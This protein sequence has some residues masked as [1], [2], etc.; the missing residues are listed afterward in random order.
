MTRFAVFVATTSG[1]VRIERI[2]RERAP[3]SMVCLRRSST[4]LPI[5]PAYDS[6]VR[7]GSGVIEKTFGP[8]EDGAFR[9]DVSEAIETGE[10]WQLGVFVAH[11]L[12]KHLL[13]A[14]DTAEAIVWLTGHVDYDLAVGSVG[15]LAEKIHASREAIAAWVALGRAVTMVVHDGPD[16]DAVL[17]AGVPEGAR[18]VTVKSAQDALDALGVKLRTAQPAVR[19]IPAWAAA[20]VA[21]IMAG[22][23]FIPLPRNTPQDVAGPVAPVAPVAEQVAMP[24]AIQ[25]DIAPTPVVAESVSEPQPAILVDAPATETFQAVQ[26]QAPAVKGAKIKLFER[27]APQ[28]HTCAEVQFGAVDPVKVPIADASDMSKSE[29]AGLCGL[30]VQ[31]DNGGEEQFVAVVLDVLSGRL[32]YGTSRPDILGGATAF[33]GDRE[34]PIDL[35][36]RMS[37]PFEIRIAAISGDQAVAEQAQWFDAQDD[38]GAAAEELE[39]KGFATAVLHHRVTP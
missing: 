29:L 23:S 10:S 13:G 8:F 21:V 26:L 9:L 34:W 22:L 5:S 25:T 7:C 33:G 37:A 28:G 31:V 18:L 2:T 12:G 1:P 27:R 17:A 30:A 20:A 3:Q 35:P 39:S 24:T 6:F 38:A 14:Q 32:L 4:V 15:H 19:R 36:R 11:A 16:R